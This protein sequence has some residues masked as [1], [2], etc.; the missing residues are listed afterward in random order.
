MKDTPRT[1][2][3]TAFGRSP[4]PLCLLVSA[5][6]ACSGAS[7][8]NALNSKVADGPGD[9]SGSTPHPRPA[10]PAAPPAADSPPPAT[11]TALP[12][13]QPPTVS[14]TAA[15]TALRRN[16]TGVLTWSANDADQCTASSDWSGNRPLSGQATIG[17]ISRSATFTLTC[18]GPGGTAVAML[19]VPVLAAVSV[20]WRPPTENVDGSPTAALAGFRIYH[21][22]FSRTYSATTAIDDPAA[23]QHT[24]TLESATHY[25]AMTAI[26]G[27]GN[28][29]DYSNEIV[30]VVE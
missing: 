20:R 29:S 11:D 22:R 24:L 28:E 5:L 6:T 14:L 3:R 13:G 9:G 21:G 26:D 18:Q 4:W 12:A 2:R 17:P 15:P 7:E 19:T 30:R 10:P 23:T 8:S 1:R 27:D 16:S 25:I